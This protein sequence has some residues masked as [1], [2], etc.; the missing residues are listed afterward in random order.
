MA[1]D[2]LDAMSDALVADT[3]SVVETP[4]NDPGVSQPQQPELALEPDKP[5]EAP[6]VTDGQPRTDTGQFAPKPTEPDKGAQPP[7]NQKP[8]T[9]EEVEGIVKLR[10]RTSKAEDEAAT[11]RREL[12]QARQQPAQIPSGQDPEAIAAYVRQT[13][14]N[15]TFNFSERVARKAHGDE[16]VNGAMDWALQ[17]ARQNSAFAAEYLKQGDPID[18]AVKQQ[19]RDKIL[20]EIGDDPDAFIR[21]RMAELSAGTV[22]PQTNEPQPSQAAQPT[23]TPQ[24]NAEPPPPRSLA[25]ANS[26]GGT[27]QVALGDEA[28]FAETFK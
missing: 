15:V 18:W 12:A 28:I 9:P 24:Q 22:T 3:A 10:I 16:T 11:L 21:K 23:P 25:S 26:A 13:E 7:V 4:P 8:L 14:A 20:N 27:G 5:K 1:D 6:P 19:K 2:F 17:R